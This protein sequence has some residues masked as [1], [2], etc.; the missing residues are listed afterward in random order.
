MNLLVC[1]FFSDR[2]LEQNWKKRRQQLLTKL[3]MGRNRAQSLKL[4]VPDNRIFTK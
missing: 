1:N 2:K 4:K 3:V